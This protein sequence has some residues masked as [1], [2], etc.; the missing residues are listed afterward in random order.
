M[1]MSTKKSGMNTGTCTMSTTIISTHRLIQ[2][3]N[4]IPIGTYTIRSSTG[5][6]ITLIRIIGMITHAEGI[7]RFL[8]SF[9]YTTIG[10]V[11]I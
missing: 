2:L 10:Q 9:G 1:N 11:R 5:T 8:I 3:I 4:R 7:L 6:R